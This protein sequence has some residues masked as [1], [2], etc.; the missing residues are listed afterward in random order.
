MNESDRTTRIACSPAGRRAR[1]LACVLLA[2]GGLA[3]AA[4]APRSAFGA[5]YERWNRG[6]R[7]AAIKAL[8]PLADAGDARAQVLLGYALIDGKE[9]ARDVPRGYAWLQIATSADVFGYAT[10]AGAAARPQVA[11][12]ATQL[13]G[14][15]L[16]A[17]DRIA[18]PYLEAHGR[19]YGEQL[20]A[21]AL[22]LTGRS[23][24]AS[25]ATLPGC[26]LDRSIGGCE[27]ARRIA[28]W[29]HSC[30]GNIYVPELPASTD[31]PDAR[32]A[33]PNL[34]VK[35]PAWE[36]VVIALVHVDTSGYACQVALLRGSGLKDVDQ[37]VLE[38]VRVWR[39]QPGIRSGTAVESLAEAR[40]ENII[41]LA[42]P[43]TPPR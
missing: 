38:A 26:A 21:A 12:L 18:G 43:A 4:D 17:A 25:V 22:V 36:G 13:P 16:I 39:F 27:E 1:L 11:T 19:A 10:A 20:K 9:V 32:L 34:P 24:D 14:A 5:A 2:V 31:G 7:K 37:A 29:S 8:Q 3:V 6:D 15:D 33:Q 23:A 30:T 35:D 41:P 42:A 28:D 40:I